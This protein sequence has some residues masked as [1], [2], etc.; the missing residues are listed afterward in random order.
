MLWVADITY[1]RTFAGWMYAA[2]VI[3]V[4]SRVVVGWQVSAYLRTS[5]ALDALNM[6]IW[7]R[8]RT[9]ADLAGL[10]HHSDRGVQYRA[11]RY[12]QHLAEEQAVTS[13]GSK[14]DSCDN[15]PH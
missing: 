3:D 9:G 11:V 5:L 15:A 10:V 13:V 12:T 6:G 1:I 7:T 8:T 2:F 4:F 14:D